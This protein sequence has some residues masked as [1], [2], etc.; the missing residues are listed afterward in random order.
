MCGH[1]LREEAE[2]SNFVGFSACREVGDR[3]VSGLFDK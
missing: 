2:V 3:K 1:D